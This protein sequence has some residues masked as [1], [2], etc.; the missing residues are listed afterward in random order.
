MEKKQLNTLLISTFPELE[1]EYYEEVD[2]Q[3]GDETGSHIVYGDV[4]AP[5]IEKNIMQQND[6]EIKTVFA[7]VEKILLRNETYSDEVIM[8]SVLE[9]LLSD[10][11][12]FEY[13]KKHFG[14]CTEK[15]IKE[16]CLADSMKRHFDINI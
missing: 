9:R 4:L 7:F 1:K 8:F 12:K 16:M 3:E 14:K 10:K 2:W 11:E 13:C 6:A 15:I 5:Y